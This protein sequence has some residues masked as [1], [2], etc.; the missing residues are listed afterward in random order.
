MVRHRDDRTNREPILEGVISRLALSHTKAPAIVVDDD[1]DVIRVVEG[2]GAAVERRVIEA[3]LRRRRLPDQL[4]EF[5]PIGLV[6]HTASRPSHKCYLRAARSRRQG[7]SPKGRAQRE[8]WRCRAQLDADH[9][10][11]DA[12]EFGNRNQHRS[13]VRSVCHLRR[14]RN[15]QRTRKRRAEHSPFRCRFAT[16]APGREQPSGPPSGRD[17]AQNRGV[18]HAPAPSVTPAKCVSC[19]A[20]DAALCGPPNSQGRDTGDLRQSRPHVVSDQEPLPPARV[21]Y[22]Y[23]CRP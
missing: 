5:P 21:S 3:P 9:V 20:Q 1:A 23:V 14:V 10:M 7:R 4:R 2:R 16:L 22:S 11:A 19:A 8:P 6:A 18:A 15:R 13:A 12:T 17:T